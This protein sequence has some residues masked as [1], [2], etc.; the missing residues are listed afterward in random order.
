MVPLFTNHSTTAPHNSYVQT[1]AA[2]VDEPRIYL[3][4]KLS[5]LKILQNLLLQSY[6]T[7]E[8]SLPEQHSLW[9]AQL[10]N[11]LVM[12][13]EAHIFFLLTFSSTGISLGKKYLKYEVVILTKSTIY[14][15]FQFCLFGAYL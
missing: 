15:T 14:A 8:I 1:G 5:T 4:L 2:P 3:K 9:L 13:L 7:T 6:S 10:V 11:S 12:R